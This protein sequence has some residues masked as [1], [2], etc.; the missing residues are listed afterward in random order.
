MSITAGRVRPDEGRSGRGPGLRSSSVADLE[1]VIPVLNE[2]L[3]LGATLDEIAVALADAP[4]SVS[5]VVVDNGCTDGT[6]DVLE[7]F[8]DRLD[9]RLVSCSERGK[10]AAVRRG[11]LET[12]AAVVAYCDADL[13]TPPSALLDGMQMVRGGHDAVIGSRRAIGAS[14]EV[15]QSLLRQ[16]GSRAFNRVAT[17]IVGPMPDTQCGFKM[18]DGALARRVFGSMRLQ[19]YAFDVELIA[20]IQRTDAV[21]AELPVS[22]SNDAGSRFNVVSDGWRSFRDLMT[23]RRVLNETEAVARA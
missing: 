21:V 14:I 5:V 10:G 12:R 15:P 3:R 16:V 7:R 11:V 18:L 17:T 8:R 2:E 19:G 6:A 4:F 1:V 20:R 13:S 9:L 22:W 23:V